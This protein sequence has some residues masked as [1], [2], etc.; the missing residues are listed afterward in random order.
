M[1]RL[2]G[3]EPRRRVLRITRTCALKKFNAHVLT[4]CT[5][6][7]F[8]KKLRFSGTPYSES[9]GSSSLTKQKR[10]ERAKTRSFFMAR[11][12]GFEPAL[13]GIGIRCVIQ[14]RHRRI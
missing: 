9:A 6:P 7:P 12:T 5:A 10:K 1:A 2:T 4:R 3:F 8:P 14:L 11:L 13:S